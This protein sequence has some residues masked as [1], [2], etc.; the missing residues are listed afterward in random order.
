MELKRTA[1]TLTAAGLIAALALIGTA[2]DNE[3]D[4]V[5][6]TTPSEH[7]SGL[8]SDTMDQLYLSTVREGAPSFADIDDATLI[9]F[10][11]SVCTGFDN[12]ATFTELAL[13]GLDSGLDNIDLGY[14]MGVG[15]G[16]YCPEYSD[17]L[18]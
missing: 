12:G 14:T 6:T 18:N 16:A 15:V 1:K 8:D 11:Q 13:M 10:G 3:A 7:A 4:S 5:D 2:C 17:Q 9:E